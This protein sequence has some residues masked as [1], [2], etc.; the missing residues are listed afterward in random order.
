MPWRTEILESRRRTQRD[1]MAFLALRVTDWN[2][3][4][5]HLRHSRYSHHSSSQADPVGGIQVLVALFGGH[6]APGRQTDRTTG[7]PA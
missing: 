1:N 5:S 7:D 3:E 2:A 6:P 4:T